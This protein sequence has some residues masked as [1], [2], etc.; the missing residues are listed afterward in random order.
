MR[1]TI[2]LTARQRQRLQE[3]VRALN[4]SPR[5]RI[6]ATVLLMSAQ[7]QGGDAIA[8]T[9]GITRRTVTN[10]RARWLCQGLR[11][12]VD[13][14]HRGRPPR[15]DARYRALLRRTVRRDPRA[16]GYAFTRWT[17]PRLAAY[18]AQCT[19]VRVTASRVAALLHQD[20]FVWRRTRHTLRNLQDPVAVQRA[21]HALGR[22]KKGL[23]DPTPGLNCGTAMA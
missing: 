13:R 15:A 8:Q 5:V 4:A 12:L 18:L 16:L 9:L 17:A 11:G 20:H 1:A 3:M 2:H 10:T 14:P 23:Y 6:R 22:F 19:G 7:G 21:E